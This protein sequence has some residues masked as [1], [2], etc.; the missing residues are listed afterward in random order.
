MRALRKV[1]VQRRPR[2][3]KPGYHQIIVDREV[4]VHHHA[5]VILDC[6]FF[7]QMSSREAVWRSCFV[8]S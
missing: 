8:S 7:K 1:R 5:K 6:H 2:V 4:Q 3:A